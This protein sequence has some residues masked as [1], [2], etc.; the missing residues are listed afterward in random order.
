MIDLRSDTIT[1]PTTAMRAAMAAATV[2]DD[3]YHDDPTVNALEDTVASL[4]GKEA[5]M[6][7]PTGTMSNQ[8][9]IRSHTEPGD[10]VVIEASAHVGTHEMGGPAHH[11]GV[12]LKPILGRLGTFTS[13]Q[14]CLLYTSDAAD[15]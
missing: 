13:D 10:V 2:G 15:D 3:V 12:T 11:S 14:L 9:A 6:Y 1:R 7:V 8:I 4:L 5:A